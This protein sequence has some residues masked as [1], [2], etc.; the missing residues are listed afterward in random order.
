MALQS[1]YFGPYL[2]Q[3]LQ[4]L[5]EAYPCDSPVYMSKLDISDAFHSCALRPA[6]VG[7]FSYVV[8]PLPSDPA[9]YLCVELV[10]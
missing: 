4:Q 6:D 1:I 9:F 8:L 7:A 3:L 5:W 2:P 10:L